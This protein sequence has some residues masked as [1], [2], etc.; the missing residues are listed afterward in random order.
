MDEDDLRKSDPRQPEGPMKMPDWM[1]RLFGEPPPP[2][3]LPGTPL[4]K[5]KENGVE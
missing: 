3:S 1:R 4:K 2:N 5:E